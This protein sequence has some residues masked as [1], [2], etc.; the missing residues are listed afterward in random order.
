MKH[1]FL[2]SLAAILLFAACESSE[3][4]QTETSEVAAP[5]AAPLSELP[6]SATVRRNNG[7]QETLGE[8]LFRQSMLA[9]EADDA[10]SAFELCRK[11]AEQGYAPA[12]F[13]LAIFYYNGDGTPKDLSKTVYWLDKAARQGDLRA[14]IQLSECYSRG[15][16]TARDDKM[17]TYWMEQAAAQG[18]AMAQYRTGTAYYRG[19][20]VTPSYEE[21]VKWYEKAAAQGLAEA[22]NDLG[23][24]YENCLGVGHMD[25]H[26][27]LKLYEQAAAQGNKIAQQNLVRL[28]EKMKQSDL[29]Y[30]VPM[31]K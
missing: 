6:S 16:G 31:N 8:E 28:K 13:N 10:K 18:D 22:Q 3:D 23:L 20:G 14:R 19:I 7:P 21:A 30:E 26:R 1:L 25:V 9:F 24:C 5:S 29:I 15:L 11:S 4:T 27:A 17:A 2:L 12:Q